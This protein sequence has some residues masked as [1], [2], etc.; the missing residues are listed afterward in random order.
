MLS[1]IGAFVLVLLGYAAFSTW[2]DKNP[3]KW[4]AMQR[5]MDESEA[6]RFAKKY[7][8]ATR[9]VP[10]SKW[11]LMTREE[12]SDVF[13]ARER[14]KEDYERL[15]MEARELVVTKHGINPDLERVGR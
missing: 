6:K 7:D 1:Y 8:S 14:L 12:K 2:K 9:R 3:E 5:E 15:S 13:A 10:A 4:A 11:I